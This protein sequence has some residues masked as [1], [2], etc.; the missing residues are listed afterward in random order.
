MQTFCSDAAESGSRFYDGECHALDESPLFI[1]EHGIWKDTGYAYIQ[2]YNPSN[3]DFPVSDCHIRI[4]QD[5]GMW[6]RARRFRL[7]ASTI[8]ARSTF[9]IA[10]ERGKFG[11]HYLPY[12]LA[13]QTVPRLNLD[14]DDAIGLFCF[15]K[16][17][18]VIG[19]EGQVSEPWQ[20]CGASPKFYTAERK[21]YIARGTTDWTKS[22]G[23]DENTC[24]WVIKTERES[25]TG[26]IT[27]NQTSS[28]LSN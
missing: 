18:D 23:T 25:R 12:Q 17:I 8:A 22:S 24:Q 28:H 4:I 14:G 10:D 27:H 11:A 2:L 6:E 20:W 13:N 19:T 3:V 15:S 21:A 1:S 16:L 9:L 5:G 26:L 7:Q